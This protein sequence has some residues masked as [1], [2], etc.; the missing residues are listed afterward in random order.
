MN[1]FAKAFGGRLAAARRSAGFTQERLAEV[2]GFS[3]TAISNYERGVH[4]PRVDNLRSLCQTLNVSS[5]VLLGQAPD[6]DATLGE[7]GTP[8]ARQVALG[9]LKATNDEARA[10]WGVFQQM[11][12]EGR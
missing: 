8:M 5:D 7:G 9:I 1:N 3:I 2:S 4:L 12:K 6:A 11:R 10:L